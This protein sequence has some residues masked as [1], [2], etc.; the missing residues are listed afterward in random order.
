M[1]PI[2]NLRGARVTVVGLGIEGVDLVRPL[3]AEGAHVTVS[4]RRTRDELAG[5]LAAIE[6]RAVTLSLGDNSPDVIASADYVF[7]SQGVPAGL[8]A[9]R[10]ARERGIPI[11]SMTE[12]F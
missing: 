2:P 6:D 5:E 12:L 4:D 1:T 7:A 11:S 3:T 9:L 10:V 8:P